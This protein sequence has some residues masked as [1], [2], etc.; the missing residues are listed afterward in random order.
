MASKLRKPLMDTELNASLDAMSF[1]IINRVNAESIAMLR[2]ATATPASYLDDLKARGLS[3]TEVRIPSRDGINYETILAI[4]RHVQD[5]SKPRPCLYWMHGGGFHWGDRLHTLEFPEDVILQCDSVCV[6]VEY[7]L[8]P[9]YT[10]DISL[11]DCYD[12]LKWTSKH[13]TDLGIDAERIMIGGISAGGGLAASTALLCRER[14]G[15]SICAQCLICPAVD[16]RMATISMDQYLEP[17]DMLP[18]CAIEDIWKSCLGDNRD[19]SIKAVAARSED[20]SGLPTAYLDV[21]SAEVLRDDTV[22]YASR[23]W[24]GFHG[25]DTFLPD[26]AV[27]QASRKAKLSWVKRTFGIGAS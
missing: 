8:A 4:L 6:S 25:F 20:L 27:A 5:S 22:A 11:E 1:P 21:G 18:R 19:V 17:S 12:G 26:A 14:Q 9:E 7:R 23:L 10:I 13:A 2:A 24:G 16:D 3:H 15:P